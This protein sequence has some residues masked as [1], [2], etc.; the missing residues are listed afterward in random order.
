MILGGY[1]TTNND[2]HC[3]L[4]IRPALRPDV[5]LGSDRNH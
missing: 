1:Y 3:L 5:V 2:G 4:R